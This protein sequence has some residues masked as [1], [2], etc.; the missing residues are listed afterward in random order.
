MDLSSD[1]LSNGGEWAYYDGNMKELWDFNR[2]SVKSYLFFLIYLQN[3]PRL[4][5]AWKKT[6]EI[7]QLETRLEIKKYFPVFVGEYGVIRLNLENQ[8]ALCFIIDRT[9]NRNRSPRL[10]TFG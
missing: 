7:N 4:S 3:H 6:F 1:F 2:N 10:E 9:N 5:Q 8:R